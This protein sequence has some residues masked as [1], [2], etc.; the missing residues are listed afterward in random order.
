M[1]CVQRQAGGAEAGTPVTPVVL[2][3]PAAAGVQGWLTGDG[4]GDRPC[5]TRVLSLSAGLQLQEQAPGV[6]PAVALPDRC[7]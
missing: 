2:P 5:W 6:E 7:S 4:D 3:G 1:W